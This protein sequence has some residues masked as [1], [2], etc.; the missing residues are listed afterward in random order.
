MDPDEE[1]RLFRPVQRLAEPNRESIF[2]RVK[3][4]AALNRLLMNVS[5]TK[6]DVIIFER[7][8]WLSVGP[9]KVHANERNRPP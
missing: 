7:A 3:R 8:R 1:I 5:L 2:A 9:C 4:E 6:V